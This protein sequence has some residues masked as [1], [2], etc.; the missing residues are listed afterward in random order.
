MSPNTQPMEI[1]EDQYINERLDQQMKWYSAK[2][3][4]NKRSFRILNIMKIIAA[5]A[6]P[7]LAA[8]QVD[9]PELKYLVG[10]L[11]LFVAIVTALLSL[12]KYEENWI[13]YRSILEKLKQEKYLYLARSIPYDVEDRLGLFVSKVESLIASET[14]GWAVYIGYKETNK[15]NTMAKYVT[16]QAIIADANATQEEQAN[17]EGGQ[18]SEG[19]SK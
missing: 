15:A 5:T 3:Q 14:S 17:T 6:I 19:G 2:S 9:H 12:M 16:K 4:T 8:L 11:G 10:G 1:N 7:F 18:A 13:Q